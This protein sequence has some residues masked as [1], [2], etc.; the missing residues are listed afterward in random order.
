MYACNKQN[1]KDENEQESWKDFPAQQKRDDDGEDR[2]PKLSEEEI[3]Y[4]MMMFNSLKATTDHRIIEE[5]MIE[6]YYYRRSLGTKI[7]KEFPRF[8][9]IGCLVEYLISLSEQEI[10]IIISSC[11]LEH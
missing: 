7:L 10:F 11:F 1:K 5:F 3:K 8:L 4:K 9:D 2:F 6:T